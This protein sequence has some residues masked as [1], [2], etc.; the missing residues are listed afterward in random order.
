MTERIVSKSVF[1][2]CLVNYKFGNL[3]GKRERMK[4][5]EQEKLSK[6][7]IKVWQN[8]GVKVLVWLSLNK[9]TTAK[10]VLTSYPFK[11]IFVQK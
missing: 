3:N 8:F 2:N 1:P 9:K 7:R 6:F 5:K 10:E 4:E 11:I